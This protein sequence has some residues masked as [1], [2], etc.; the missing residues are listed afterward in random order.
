MRTRWAL[1]VM[2]ASIT[3]VLASAPKARATLMAS[4]TISTNQTSAPFN[5]TVTLHNT[6]TTNIGTFWFGW[7]P[8]ED[9]LGTTPT[10]F[11]KP[12][13][14]SATLNGGGASDGH[15][16]EFV[17]SGTLLAPGGTL[18][19]FGFTSNDTPTQLSGKS[20]FHSTTPVTT[21]IVYSGG[22]FSD[23]GFQFT[24]TVVPEPSAIVLAAVG[25]LAVLAWCGLRNRQPAVFGA[26]PTTSWLRRSLLRLYPSSIPDRSRL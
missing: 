11:V 25:G 21:S 19:G 24:A 20:P 16:I 18:S 5:Y 15:S 7:V 17:D 2:I 4:A 14:W 22:P 10:N 1:C 6:G 3:V 9:F 26:G 12:S 23:S 8:G 13:G